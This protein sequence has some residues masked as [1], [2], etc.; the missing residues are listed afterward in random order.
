MST[1]IN[2]TTTNGVVIQPDNSGS[3]QLATNSGTTAVTIDTSQNVGIG[4]ASPNYKL[5][6]GGQTGGTATPLAIRFSNDYSNGSTAASSKIFLYNDGTTGNIFGLGVGSSADVQ[7]H[8]GSTGGS[9]GNHRWYTNDTERMR[10]DSSGNLLFNSGY[11]S[12]ATAYGCRAWVNFNGTGTVAINA[13]GNVTS[14]TDN[15]TGDY[16]V[17]FTNAMPNA[18]Y[19]ITA[20][21]PVIADQGASYQFGLRYP[22]GTVGGTPTLKSTTQVRVMSRRESDQD[23]SNA[24]VAIFR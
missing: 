5:T 12:V 15:G 13:S 22:S 8:S 24:N 4:T 3:L 9:T 1:I 6:F 10:I 14:I 20:I 11:G 17:N 18:N 19:A 7:Y 2:A 16:T 23:L 21:A